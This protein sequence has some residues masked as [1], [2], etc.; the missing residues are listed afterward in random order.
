MSPRDY[1]CIKPDQELADNIGLGEIMSFCCV[2]CNS[3]C[4]WTAESFVQLV[5]D[6]GN[7]FTLEGVGV[8][9][10]GGDM[11]EYKTPFFKCSNSRQLS[12]CNDAQWE[13]L[14]GGEREGREAM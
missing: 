8:W 10:L 1:S 7:T 14:S 12:R 9:G 13:C 3:S 4:E 5:L 6:M 11:H 2:S